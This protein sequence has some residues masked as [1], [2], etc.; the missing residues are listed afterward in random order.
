VIAFRM[1][2]REMP[3]GMTF[4]TISKKGK[5]SLG[6]KTEKGILDAKVASRMLKKKAPVSIDDLIR[7]GN[8]VLL[9]W[10]AQRLRAR[11]QGVYS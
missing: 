3:K 11:R 7:H 6:I 9:V 4:V 1:L 5:Y 10:R 8:Q 2:K